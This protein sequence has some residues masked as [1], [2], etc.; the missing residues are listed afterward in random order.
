MYNHSGYY[1]IQYNFTVQNITI[2]HLRVR[3]YCT[4]IY[5]IMVLFK[6]DTKRMSQNA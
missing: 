1:D 4:D 2:T 5:A 3:F 6:M